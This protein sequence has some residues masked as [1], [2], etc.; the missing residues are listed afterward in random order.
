MVN[1]LLTEVDAQRD[2]INRVGR[3]ASRAVSQLSDRRLLIKGATDF[4]IPESHLTEMHT[5][6]NQRYTEM[7]EMSK[8]ISTLKLENM[9]ASSEINQRCSS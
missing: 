9:A 1:R 7:E 8:T 3:D 4:S 6:V 5:L 2:E